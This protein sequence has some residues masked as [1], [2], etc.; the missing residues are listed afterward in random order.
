M[1]VPLGGPLP[2]GAIPP[3]PDLSTP[4]LFVALLE[5]GAASRFY[6]LE[7]D[8]YDPSQ[9]GESETAPLGAW[10][11]GAIPALPYP[12]GRRT[13]YFASQGYATEPDDTPAD[14]P[15]RARL[16]VALNVASRLF[17]GEEPS[18][19]GEASAGE[20]RLLQAGGDLAALT[21]M[22]WDGARIAVK[23]GAPGF[24]YENFPTVYLGTADGVA[25]SD[26]AISIRLRDRRALL[27]VP[28]IRPTPSET[29]RYGG[30]GG[31]DGSPEIAG[32][33][34]LWP[35]GHAFNVAPIQIDPGDPTYQV[36]WRA[37][38]A[39]TAVR[40]KGI[41]LIGDGDV[42]TYAALMAATIAGGHYRTC[43]AL[44]LIRLGD[45]AAGTITCDVE[46]DNVADAIG[47]F[48]ETTGDIMRRIVSQ[49]ANFGAAELDEASFIALDLARPF[50]IGWLGS[51]DLTAAAACDQLAAAIHAAHFFDR[52]GR[53]RIAGLA[54]PELADAG[55]VEP[56]DVDDRA[57]SDLV[58]IRPAW[59]RRVGWGRNWQV[60]TPDQ[61]G[62]L[63]DDD[64]LLYGAAERQVED[65]D[66]G[67]KTKHALA[68]EATTSTFIAAEADAQAFAGELKRLHGTLRRRGSFTLN[69]ALF[70]HRLG[71]VVAVTLPAYGLEDVPMIV[72]AL[73]ED[74]QR[75][76]VTLELWG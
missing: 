30:A 10:P 52:D 31:L 49:A 57:A 58:Q 24:A 40:D 73:T 8:A 64:R 63:S 33:A 22:G 75:D 48:V 54:P 56:A 59:V 53:Q 1:T 4:D 20:I 51:A 6:I 42:A 34:K 25:W 36:S 72:V 26:R 28:L 55:E 2:I 32:R 47:G 18:G 71:D 43:L 23:L 7:A 11:I 13:L 74:A 5:A 50:P 16:A 60:Q 46:G 45:Q 14:T 35:L 3:A 9:A 68:R 66:A 61:L 12:V 69:D 65:R 39:I 38:Q 15:M 17:A 27:D 19:A 37:V 70:R 44:G 76:A 41:A 29:G 62:E 67:I 21:R